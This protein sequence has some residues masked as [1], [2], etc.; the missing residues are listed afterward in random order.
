[1]QGLNSYISFIGQAAQFNPEILDNFDSD[2][3]ANIYADI[4]GVPLTVTRTREA[5]QQMRQIRQQQQQQEKAKQ[6]ALIAAQ[7]GGQAGV[8]AA[9]NALTRAQAGQVLAE[10][11]QTAAQTGMI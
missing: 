10:T 3:A 9:N 6:E 7:V 2:A 4:T 5:V 8:D 11:Q 1:M